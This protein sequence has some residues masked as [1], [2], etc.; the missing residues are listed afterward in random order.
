VP[1]ALFG[2][3]RCLE[4]AGQFDKAEEIYANFII[5]NPES[6]WIAQAES[7]L[8]L[9]KRLQRLNKRNK[10]STSANKEH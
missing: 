10:P 9:V 3:A 5:E 2:K 1:Q 4:I 8:Q 7:A 6:S